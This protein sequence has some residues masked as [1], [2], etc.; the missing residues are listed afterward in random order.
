MSRPRAGWWAYAK[1]MA[2]HYPDRVNE[3]EY[4]AV[5]EA[6]EETERMRNAADRLKVVN[7]VLIGDSHTLE[8]AA[9]QIP[10]STRT[11]QRWHR[12]FLRAVGRHFRCN[13][14]K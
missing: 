5:K 4:A 1:Y 3:E 14:L 13:G 2:R 11:A 12:D 7:M 9:L 8:G 10:C 6:L